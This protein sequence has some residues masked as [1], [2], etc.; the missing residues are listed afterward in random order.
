MQVRI[1]MLLLVATIACGGGTGGG[2][3]LCGSLAIIGVGREVVF[4]LGLDLTSS[5]ELFLAGS[6]G[7]F[8]TGLLLL[9]AVCFLSPANLV[10][11]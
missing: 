7:G 8:K 11:M 3:K 2:G 1:A 5:D 10:I 4:G 9:L 6:A